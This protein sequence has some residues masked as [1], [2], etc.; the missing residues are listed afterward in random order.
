LYF[1]KHRN[2]I[3][4]QNGSGK[5]TYLETLAINVLLAQIG[6]WVPAEKL[7]YR[8]FDSLL[9][10]QCGGSNQTP[11]GFSSQV[12]AVRAVLNE[13]L[14][15]NLILLDE[16]GVGVEHECAVSLC[17]A[18][19][20]SVSSTMG[21][22]LLI[23]THLE[24]LKLMKFLYNH[25]KHLSLSVKDNGYCQQMA[26]LT[27]SLQNENYGLDAA[28]KMLFPDTVLNRARLISSSR[29]EKRTEKIRI[30][31]TENMRPKF[32]ETNQNF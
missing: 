30:Q 6:C 13:T 22:T 20:E 8:I 32:I 29:D 1:K 23:S 25:I 5:T 18:V 4:G 9:F 21:C 14:D 16:L 17:W 24:E 12:G 10:Q 26:S 28:Q 7:E 11:Q 31:V 15:N 19:A 27:S 3:S 2:L